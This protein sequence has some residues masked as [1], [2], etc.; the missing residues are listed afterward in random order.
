MIRCSLPYLA[1]SVLP[2]DCDS[3]AVGT[4][5][6]SATTLHLPDGTSYCAGNFPN[7]GPV[8][9]RHKYSGSVLD[10]VRVIYFAIQSGTVRQ[11]GLNFPNK[12][13]VLRRGEQPFASGAE[14]HRVNRIA[15]RK[16]PLHQVPCPYVPDPG[17]SVLRSRC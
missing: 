6:C 9:L 7:S 11:A 2:A 12:N 13:V 15:V 4:E 17:I 14:A 8:V 1:L 5:I 16:W 3:C 10:E